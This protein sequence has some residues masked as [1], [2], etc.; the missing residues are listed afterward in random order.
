[1]KIR[2]DDLCH[3]V[4]EWEGR[5]GEEIF[6]CASHYQFNALLSILLTPSQ[7]RDYIQTD[8]RRVFTV[9][10]KK[11]ELGKQYLLNNEWNKKP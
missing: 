1:M 5:R 9:S 8:T 7:E 2:L 10:D 3:T 6:K 11:I 4:E